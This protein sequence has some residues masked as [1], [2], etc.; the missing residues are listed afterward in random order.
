MKKNVFYI[1]K[2]QNKI[3]YN[4]TYNNDINQK[5]MRGRLCHID[6]VKI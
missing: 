2:L 3:K 4:D 5:F 6:R 1:C